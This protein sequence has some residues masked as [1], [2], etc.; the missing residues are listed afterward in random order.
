MITKDDILLKLKEL[1]PAL[2]KEYAVKEIGLFSS[3]TFNEE[4]DIEDLLLD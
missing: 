1:K 4:S 3:E 2:H